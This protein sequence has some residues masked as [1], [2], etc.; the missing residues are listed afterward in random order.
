MTDEKTEKADKVQHLQMVE[1]VIQRMA[2]N[3]FQLKGWSL[4]VASIIA[5]LVSNNA[6]GGVMFI[7]LIP[8][9]A[10]WF[11]DSYYL[12]L[13]RKYRCLYDKVRNGLITDYDMDIDK[14]KSEED[15]ECKEDKLCY[16]N[17]LFSKT[18][19]AFYFS[20]GAAMLVLS[21]ALVV[22]NCVQCH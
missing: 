22:Y 15:K 5:A 8:V 14:I 6:P 20:V 9:V 18:E 1:N 4:T 12:Q 2:A 21:I 19:K 13:E 7:T 16:L 10:F 11:L 3:S 17:C